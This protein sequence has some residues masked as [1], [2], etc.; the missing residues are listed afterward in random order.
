[1]AKSSRP[2]WEQFELDYFRRLS[3][4]RA[5]KRWLCVVA[6]LIPAAWVALAA[7]RNDSSL[8]DS[9]PMADAHAFLASDCAKCHTTPWRAVL[10]LTDPARADRAMNEACLR[11]HS[12]SIAHDT[13][14][15]TARH[16]GAEASTPEPPMACAQCHT[17][18]QGP[19]KLAE[20]ATERCTSCHQG[21]HAIGAETTFHDSITAFH[22]DHPQFRRLTNGATDASRIKLN[23]AVHLKPNL[24]SPDGPVQ[25]ACAD[26]H[27]AGRSAVA[28]PYARPGLHDDVVGSAAPSEPQM[29]AAYMEPIRYSLHCVRCHEL[30]VDPLKELFGGSAIV[31]HD[32]PAAIQ[33]FLRGQLTAFIQKHPEALS[34]RAAGRTDRRPA[35][36]DAPPDEV[37]R[38]SLEWVEEEL[39]AL[40]QQMYFDKKSCVY[41]HEQDMAKGLPGRLPRIVPPE[42]PSRWFEHASFDHSRHRVLD[43]L[44]CHAGASEST[45]TSDVLLPGIETCRACHAPQSGRG[46]SAT[47]GVADDCS[48]CHTYHQPARNPGPGRTL[49]ELTALRVLTEPVGSAPLPPGRTTP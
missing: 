49:R 7:V 36:Q 45:R 31:P 48:T 11:C 42:I 27:R 6:A 14:T 34:R 3:P 5:A 23:H 26:C 20:V 25:M 32:E 10:S 24:R 37:N 47:G 33:T 29:Q 41:C 1:M 13:Q 46:E 19:G 15:F 9:G 40:E 43:C 17:E 35:L 30:V 8:Y 28:W 12:Q 21:L 4:Y 39:A 44:E 22:A 18:H 16:L 2:F 38:L